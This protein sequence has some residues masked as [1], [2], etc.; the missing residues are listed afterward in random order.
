MSR[1]DLSACRRF[2]SGTRQFSI[3]IRPFWTTLS[4]ILFWIFSTLKPG[5]V[6]FS[7]MKALTWLSSTSR[8]QM[9]EM[10]HHG[11]LPIHF[12]WPLKI[13][14]SPSRFAVV[15]MPPEVPRAH[16]GLGKA[17]AADL[18][19]ARHWREPLLF[20]LLRSA[21]IDGPHCQAVVDTEERGDRCVDAR[22]FHCDQPKKECASTSAA[23]AV[24]CD[25][26]DV[27]LLYARQQFKG[28]GIFYPVL[29]DDG[30]N[31]VFHERAYLFHDRQFVGRQG[32]CEF[33]KVTI[34]RRQLLWRYERFLG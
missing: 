9:T 2:S 6:L 18:F 19:P 5:V 8:A 21:K 31:L 22:H 17:E 3:V 16:Q 12:F 26:A 30:S 11:E 4:A 33:V 28:K 14:V 27:E 7:T 23:I 1:N 25:A 20:L 29:R 32:L 34:G 10:S 24:H 15:V 13:Q